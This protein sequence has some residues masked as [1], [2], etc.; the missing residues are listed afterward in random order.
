MVMQAYGY[1]SLRLC[2]PTVRSARFVC[3][4]HFCMVM[5]AYSYAR[6][7]LCTPTSSEKHPQN[8]V[9]YIIEDHNQVFKITASKL[10]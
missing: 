2:K 4:A 9:L 8:Y 3:F 6:L 10:R 7:Q 1:A 5:H